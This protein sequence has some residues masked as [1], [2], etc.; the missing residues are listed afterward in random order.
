M[1]VEFI[2]KHFGIIAFIGVTILLSVIFGFVSILVLYV[3]GFIVLMIIY[4]ISNAI[5]TKNEKKLKIEL[6]KSCVK[7][8]YMDDN[9]W[10]K[11]L[12]K[13]SGKHYLSSFQEITREFAE[14]NE[15]SYIDADQSLKWLDP[16]T[17]YLSNAVMADIFELS[18]IYSEGLQYTH[19]TPNAE[20]IYE[21][22]ENLVLVKK[23]NGK[24]MI[25]KIQL[26]MEAVIEAHN[27]NR[28]QEI[29]EFYKTA[30]KIDDYFAN[31]NANGGS[32]MESEEIS[33]D[34]L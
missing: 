1:I 27:L 6:N 29:P 24:Q 23:V 9:K 32:N 18:N 15:R 19:N 21:A 34:D 14:I 8:G 33:L 25:H 17:K 11:Q 4:L 2:K 28:Q 7:L 31:R 22:M 30:Y 16:I 13:F 5:G 26:G 12:P 3:F 10:R 20:L